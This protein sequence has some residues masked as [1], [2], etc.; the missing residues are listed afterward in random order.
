MILIFI[1]ENKKTGEF[2]L[3]DQYNLFGKEI[4]FWRTVET[5]INSLNYFTDGTCS[6]E[7][8]IVEGYL[9]Y[10]NK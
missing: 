5:N 10:Y 2:Y 7:Y 6:D 3:A 4:N 8:F 9:K 1:I